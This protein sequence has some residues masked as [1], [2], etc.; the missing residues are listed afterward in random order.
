MGWTYGYDSIREI[1]AEVLRERSDGYKVL[2]S[3]STNYGRNLWVAYQHPKGY[4]FIALYMI[5]KSGGDYGYKD[6]DES[7]GPIEA[8]CPI[9]LLDLV[10]MPDG[11]Y[12]KEWRER[13]Y[14]HHAK[15]RQKFEVGQEVLIYGKRYKIID[16]IRR[17]Y[18]VQRVSDGVVYRCGASKMQSV[19]DVEAKDI[20]E[21]V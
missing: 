13:V 16:T 7:C 10:P 1:K 21:A 17:S 5:G 12:A 6:M 4:K 9:R 2:D 19:Q 20:L 15:R 3:A 11:G 18:R 8:D 14:A